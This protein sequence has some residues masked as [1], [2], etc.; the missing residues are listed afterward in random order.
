MVLEEQDLVQRFQIHLRD[1]RFQAE[2][3]LILR[4]DRLLLPEQDQADQLQVLIR[5]W[6]EVETE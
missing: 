5:L 2:E 4:L 1:Q 6:Q 3:F